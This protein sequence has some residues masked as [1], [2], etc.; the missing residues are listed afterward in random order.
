[1][2]ASSSNQ[3]ALP[4]AIQDKIIPRLETLE[5]KL[6]HITHMQTV[7]D[8]HSKRVTTQFNSWPKQ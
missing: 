5:N 4:E 8:S 7:L 2:Q 6:P 3:K 1:M